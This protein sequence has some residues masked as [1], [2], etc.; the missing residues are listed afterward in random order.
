[1]KAYPVTVYRE[2]YRGADSK[3]RAKMSNYNRVAGRIEAHLNNYLSKQP[4]DT[5]HVF[6]S[7]SIASQLGERSDI[8]HSIVFG[9]DGGSNGI[10]VV[11]GN[12]DRAMAARDERAANRPSDHDKGNS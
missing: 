2:S 6:L 12:F 4:D 9:T 7:Y 5:V 10:T 3:K 1:M 11:K 8:V